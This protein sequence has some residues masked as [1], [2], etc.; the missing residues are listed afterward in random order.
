[1]EFEGFGYAFS[2]DDAAWISEKLLEASGQQIEC[3]QRYCL[4]ET[5]RHQ[6]HRIRG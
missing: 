6:G 4:F 3:Y 1:M 2:K 5:L